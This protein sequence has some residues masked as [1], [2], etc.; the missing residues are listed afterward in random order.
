MAHTALFF[1][2][3]TARGLDSLR[4]LRTQIEGGTLPDLGPLSRESL[5][6][7]L[8]KAE[9]KLDADG[10][11][12]ASMARAGNVIVP[13]VFELGEPLGRPDQP[14]PAFARKSA[15]VD[16]TGFGFPASQSQQP[17]AAI[18]EA[19]V[20]VAHLNQLQDRDGAVRQEPL[21]LNFDGHA[22]PS[23]GLAVAAHSLNLGVQDLRLLPGEGV[24]LGRLRIPTDELARVLPQFYPDP[25]GRPAFAVDSFYDV[26]SGRI[27]ATKYAGKIVIVGATAAGVGN[28][29]TTP[30]AAAMSPAVILAHI[31]SSILQG[32]FIARPLWSGIA[33]AARVLASQAHR[34]G[35]K[36]PGFRSPPRVIG[37]DR[38]LRRINGGVVVSVLLRGRPF[39]AVLS[40]MVEGVVVANRLIGREAEIARTVLWASVES[41]LVSDEAQT[42]VA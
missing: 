41:L 4:E 29:F 42:R 39:V 13:S 2:P 40:D 3:Q 18:G 31:T 21:L 7:T 19:A 28:V 24:Q 16:A 5:V 9:E 22:V 25:D 10:R 6:L 20:A 11:L 8:I 37:V 23:M 27:P 14:L 36:P 17:I 34:H 1:E 12:V 35:L 32:H 33:V 38:S 15:L 30:V 26:V